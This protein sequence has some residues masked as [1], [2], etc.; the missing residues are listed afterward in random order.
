MQNSQVEFEFLGN[1]HILRNV[2]NNF[3][4]PATIYFEM[5]RWLPINS[6]KD[7]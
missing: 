4:V 6:Y 3:S 7:L 1:A 5:R 2:Q